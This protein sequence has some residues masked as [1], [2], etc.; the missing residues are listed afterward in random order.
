VLA[1][2]LR[3]AERHPEPPV[4]ATPTQTCHASGHISGRGREGARMFVPMLGYVPGTLI[5]VLLVVLIV[6]LIGAFV[7]QFFIRK[8]GPDDSGI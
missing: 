7:Y 1:G 8:G 6:G 5:A 4:R 3:E 2:M